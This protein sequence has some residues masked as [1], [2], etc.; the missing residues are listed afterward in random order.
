VLGAA[1]VVVLVQIALLEWGQRYS[2]RRAQPDTVLELL[3]SGPL[4]T[5]HVAQLLLA[6]LTLA[7]IT[8]NASRIFYYRR[9]Y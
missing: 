7:A 3:A 6:A 1:I 5:M 4:Q 9:G 2:G 8:L